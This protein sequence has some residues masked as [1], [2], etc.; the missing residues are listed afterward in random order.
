MRSTGVVR[1]RPT[2]SGPDLVASWVWYVL[3]SGT[4]TGADCE[5][6]ATAFAQFD[7]GPWAGGLVGYRA[8]R[9]S[10]TTLDSVRCDSVDP[11]EPR[12]EAFLNL[13]LDNVGLGSGG[14]TPS[15]LAPCVRWVTQ[16]GSVRSRGR[17]YLTALDSET[18]EDADANRIADDAAFALSALFASWPSELVSLA[19]G[20]A[21]LVSRQSHGVSYADSPVSLIDS[22]VMSS[23]S[24]STQRRRLTGPVVA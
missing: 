23:R 8:F 22:A 2:F 21:V 12:T 15:A 9:S 24:R 13:G 3:V 5:A 4:P 20:L 7:R 17:T 11:A 19:L 14:P 6:L 16:D 10:L 18:L 1:I